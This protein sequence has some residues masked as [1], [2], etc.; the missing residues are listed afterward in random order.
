MFRDVN[1]VIVD[2]LPNRA[3]AFPVQLEMVLNPDADVKNTVAATT[4]PVNTASAV[5]PEK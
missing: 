2:K 5:V 3:G 4:Q 1:L